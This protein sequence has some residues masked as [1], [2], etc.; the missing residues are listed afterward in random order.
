M[1]AKCL[2]PT[3]RWEK[4][5]KNWLCIFESVPIEGLQGSSMLLLSSDGKLASGLDDAVHLPHVS[6]KSL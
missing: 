3:M 4:K 6:Y 2:M 5:N 1:F